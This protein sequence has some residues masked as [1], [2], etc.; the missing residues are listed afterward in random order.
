MRSL[1]L[2]AAFAANTA[3]GAAAFPPA[4]S[5]EQPASAHAF[6][7]A[8]GSQQT[9]AV[10]SNGQMAFAV[11]LDQRRGATDLY[12][13]RLNADGV[14]LDPLGIVIATGATGGDVFWNG[15]A[16]VVIGEQGPQTTFSFV[17][18]EGVIADRKSKQ[19]VNQLTATMGTGS[20]TRILF[21]GD[22]T[23]MILDSQANF[24]TIGVDLAI[25]FLE[26]AV[27]AASSGSE[28]LILH[29]MPGTDRPLSADRIDRNG[30]FLG[31][32]DT[33]LTLA[34]TG[35]TLA[36]A[37]GPDEY[38]LVSRG[39]NDQSGF[40]AHLDKTGVKK[41]VGNFAP[42]DRTL[43]LSSPAAKPG[44]VFDGAAYQIAWT[45]SE[46]DGS[47]HTW[48]KSE[49]AGNGVSSPPLSQFLSWT[50]TGYGVVMA[51]AGSSL[52]VITDAFRA[53]ES[54]SIDSVVSMTSSPLHPTL[55][56]TATLQVMPQV[57]SSSNGYAVVWN[58]Y[59]PDGSSRLYLRRFSQALA[60]APVD[61]APIEVA[62]DPNG[63]AITASVAAAGDT[64]VIAWTSATSYNGDTYVFRRFSATTG[65]WLDAE[66][67]PLTVAKELVLG[68]NGDGTLAV[69]SVPCQTYDRCLRARAI[70]TDTGAALLSNETSPFNGPAFEISIASNGHDYLIAW[71]DNFCYYPCDVVI[72]SRILALRLAADGKALDAAPLVVDGTPNSP[73]GIPSIAW[74]GNNYAVS[75]RRGFSS[76]FGAHVSSAGVTDAPRQILPASFIPLSH[77]L[78]AAGASLL[79]LTT[80]ENYDGAITITTSGVGLDPQSLLPTGEPAL[81]VADQPPNG[82]VSAV[83]LPTGVVIAYD[84][85]E[86]SAASVGRVFTRAFGSVAR[87]RAAR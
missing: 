20:D 80:Q 43:R 45:T 19:I 49:P 13:S 10:A 48:G 73:E 37:G 26:S 50:G 6:G 68:S 17:T 75:W 8:A 62:S 22:G 61:A 55:S 65:S 82:S 59:G 58:E 23:A 40:L 51:K 46:A 35:R 81:L 21:V 47:A 30:N 76:I 56:S 32:A 25:P 78:V 38:L 3:I 33:G 69:Y 67:V 39:P 41:R 70:A 36:L 71:N 85:V 53:G 86:Q 5:P 9:L 18:P 57:A 60:G 28:F 24:V 2:I 7:A 4:M 77:H 87:R 11:W 31:T 72:P 1:L 52:I 27:V 12:G 63:H 84:R 42:N 64:Y 79:L 14:P 34:R 29:T 16:F 74:S 54:T 83:A 15:T 44:V 66:P